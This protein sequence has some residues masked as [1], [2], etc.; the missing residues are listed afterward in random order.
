TAKDIPHRAGLYYYSIYCGFKGFIVPT[1]DTKQRSNNLNASGSQ[2]TMYSFETNEVRCFHKENKS[3]R[4]KKNPKK[5]TSLEMFS[6]LQEQNH[7]R[8]S[9]D[10][11]KQKIHNLCAQT[12]LKEIN[13]IGLALEY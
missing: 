1:E 10:N 13:L 7:K 2:E 6:T 4:R 9:R 11:R 8:L 12:P 3:R 5:R